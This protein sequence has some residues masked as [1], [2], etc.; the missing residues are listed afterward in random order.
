MLFLRT[1][2][3]ARRARI[4]V[5]P[6]DFEVTCLSGRN[7]RVIAVGILT[8]VLSAAVSSAS[9]AVASL[10]HVG[11]SILTLILII[12]TGI[13]FDIIGTAATA[14]SEAPINAM[15][16]KRVR[17][18]AEALH[19]VRNAPAVANFCNDV[20][21]DICGTVSG[22]GGATIV[23]LTVGGGTGLL[24]RG[25][26][27]VVVGLVSALTVAGKAAGK[28]LA[29]EKA[30]DVIL[31]AGRV[32]A[33]WNSLVG[34]N[35]QGRRPSGARPAQSHDHGQR[36]RV[37]ARRGARAENGRANDRTD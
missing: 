11:L 28:Q 31:T 4:P 6:W 33:S 12:A 8:F 19:L 25:M 17:G 18:S 15:A 14:A 16:A 29:I 34:G 3:I 27:T 20:V 9:E 37:S 21:G 5:I 13:V 2:G 36:R 35:T 1:D 22:A 26:P 30:N 24:A 32:L 23:L 10:F 7:G